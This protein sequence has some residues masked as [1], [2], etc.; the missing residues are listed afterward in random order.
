MFSA[1]SVQLKTNPRLFFLL[2]Q[3][4]VRVRRAQERELRRP[5]GSG[6]LRG[7]R[8]CTLSPLSAEL[9]STSDVSIPGPK[10]ESQ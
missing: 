10:M 7:A 5:G 6:E 2:S 4:L 8:G 9:R 1:N 3:E